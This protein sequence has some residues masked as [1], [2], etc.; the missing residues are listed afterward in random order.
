MKDGQGSKTKNGQ[1]V[2]L[3]G[4]LIFL[5]SSFIALTDASASYTQETCQTNCVPVGSTCKQCVKTT[6]G[7]AKAG[8]GTYNISLTF[9]CG[10]FAIG[11]PTGS[12]SCSSCPTGT[13]DKCGGLRTG[14]V[15]CGGGGGA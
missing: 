5:T 6:P 12:G 3:A 7:R 1:S 4:L 2:F 11:T 9:K 8:G 13:S 15:A 10:E 14:T